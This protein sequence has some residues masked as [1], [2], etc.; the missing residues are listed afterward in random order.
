MH[1]GLGL[2]LPSAMNMI[3]KMSQDPETQCT[4]LCMLVLNEALPTGETE[5]PKL[6]LVMD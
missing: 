2:F 6:Q 1:S 3:P 5:Y 4:H